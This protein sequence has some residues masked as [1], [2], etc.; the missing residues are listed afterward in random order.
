VRLMFMPIGTLSIDN[1]A[2]FFCQKC[3]GWILLRRRAP[4]PGQDSM[5]AGLRYVERVAHC[6]DGKH[7][8]TPCL[9]SCTLHLV[10]QTLQVA[11][12]QYN[13]EAALGE[14]R[15]HS[16]F[17]LTGH[18]AMRKSAP[19][20]AW[21]TSNARGEDVRVI[22]LRFRLSGFFTRASTDAFELCA[23]LLILRHKG[24]LCTNLACHSSLSP[25][26]Q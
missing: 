25:G 26:R 8:E 6:Q 19:I 20:F 10:V 18:A 4:C 7:P 21:S 11:H 13:T 15:A 16:A 2:S 9:S 17:M 14:H 22:P 24:K 1:R 23:W 12:R 5:Q 3:Q